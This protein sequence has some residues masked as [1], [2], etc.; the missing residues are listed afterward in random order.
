MERSLMTFN[1]LNA[2]T[3][4]SSV[5]R[6]ASKRSEQAAEFVKRE[7]PDILCLQ[8]FDYYYRHHGSFIEGI[9][10]EYAEADT[11]DELAG[12]GWNAIFYRKDKYSVIESGG[13]NFVEN[14]FGIVP[15]KPA[16]GEIPPTRHSNCHEYR[17]PEDSEEGRAGIHRTR[18]RSLGWALLEDRDGE[19]IIVA[20][21]HFS[22]RSSCQPEESN[23]VLGRLWELKEKYQCRIIVCGDFNSNCQ[24]KGSAAAR[25][26][27]ERFFDTYDMAEKRD[28]VATCHPSSGKGVSSETDRMPGGS[29]KPHAID[30]IFTD[31]EMAVKCFRIYAE[32]E[33]LSVSDHCPVMIDF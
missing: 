29:Y 22:L 30:H 28:D 16:E 9:S 21:T 20:T 14:G 24:T 12:N 8:E 18:F 32:Q 10:D 11:R 13:W 33:L 1:V 6:T 19:R 27:E 2:W 15:I 25:L 26:L 23:F 31:S 7:L 3:P 4:N 5:Y 17:Y